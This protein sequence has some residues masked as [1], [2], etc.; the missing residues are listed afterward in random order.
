MNPDYNLSEEELMPG[1]DEGP[2]DKV[3]R[4]I[5]LRCPKCLGHLKEVVDVA[6]GRRGMYYDCPACAIRLKMWK[7]HPGDRTVLP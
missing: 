1:F 4:V 7:Y 2:P 6:P 5:W 3:E